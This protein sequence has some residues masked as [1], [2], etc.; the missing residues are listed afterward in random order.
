MPRKLVPTLYSNKKDGPMHEVL[1]N[2]DLERVNV[3][4]LYP[5]KMNSR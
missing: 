3:G 1:I 4:I 5:L 2:M